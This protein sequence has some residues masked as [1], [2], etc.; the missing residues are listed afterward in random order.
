MTVGKRLAQWDTHE[1]AEGQVQYLVDEEGHSEEEAYKMVDDDNDLFQ[2]AWDDLE[3]YL[4]ELMKRGDGAWY[5]EVNDFGWRSLDGQC[6]FS[7][8]NGKDFLRAILPD[9]DCTFYIHD[10][11]DGKGFAIQNYHHDS[12]VGKEWYYVLPDDRKTCDWCGDL[13]HNAISC[14]YCSMVICEDC[15]SNAEPDDEYYY[16]ECDLSIGSATVVK[17]MT[18]MLVEGIRC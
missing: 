3:C 8:E 16:C 13:I 2:M 6:Y 18:D 9:T 14:A 12:P 1:I 15:H 10:Y 11:Y 7:A 17:M 4:T 5:A